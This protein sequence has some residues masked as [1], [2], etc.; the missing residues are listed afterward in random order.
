MIPTAGALGSLPE[1][2]AS[3][4]AAGNSSA[5]ITGATIAHHT[6]A[7]CADIAS[8]KNTASQSSVVHRVCVPR[9]ARIA[10][11]ASAE[12]I[13]NRP[14]T[15]V[16]VTGAHSLIVSRM[17]GLVERSYAY[18]QTSTPNG[19]SNV[20]AT[21][22]R[23]TQSS[24]REPR[25]VLPGVLDPRQP[26]DQREDR[27]APVDVGADG[28]QHRDQVQAT[29]GYLP[30]RERPE[31]DGEQR[32]GDELRA[33][34]EGRR[35][36][37]EPDHGQEARRSARTRPGRGRRGRRTRTRLRPGQPG[38]TRA[39]PSRRTGG[40]GRGRSGLPTVGRAK[41]VRRR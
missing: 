33:H 23:A 41:D 10:T 6:I 30:R 4:A 17:I 26:D 32:Q 31:R 12:P 21:V 9:R 27:E 34:R 18:R 35:S 13:M 5:R 16:A 14:E 1:G 36:H 22:A 29:W 20:A 39:W 8:M 25:D 2:V 3:A 11:T 15:S 24:R 37:E 19:F 7:R 38:G 40:P 28:S